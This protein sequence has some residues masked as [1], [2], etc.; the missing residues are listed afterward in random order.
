M[1]KSL[2]RNHALAPDPLALLALEDAERLNLRLMHPQTP[3][4]PILQ[5]AQIQ[6]DPVALP[7]DAAHDGASHCVENEMVGG[8]DDGDE[9]DGRVEQT[10]QHARDSPGTGQP[11]ADAAADHD[12]SGPLMV[13]GQGDRGHGEADEQAVSEVQGWHGGVLVAEF[14]LGPDGALALCAMHGVDEAV[15]ARL[16]RQ[17][18]LV[19]WV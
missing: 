6:Q 4:E 9:D 2:L 18:A 15:A 17:F 5:R 3:Q 7:R 8:G 16:G 10:Q 13:R 12:T 14:V 11:Q 1:S 19:C